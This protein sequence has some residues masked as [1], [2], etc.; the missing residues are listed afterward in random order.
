MFNLKSLAV[1]F[2][3]AVL[4]SGPVHAQ[5]PDKAA[6][7]DLILDAV[8]I[9]VAESLCDN[10]DIDGDELVEIGESKHFL[11]GKAGLTK[12]EIAAARGALE[13]EAK[14]DKAAFCAG[15]KKNYSAMYKKLLAAAD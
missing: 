5:S 10:V 12:V 1:P 11:R 3:F 15:L 8:A 6:L 4:L 7:Q 9:E 2:V 14:K 13:G